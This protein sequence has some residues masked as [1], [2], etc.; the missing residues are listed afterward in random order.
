ML[1]VMNGK[2]SGGFH[3]TGPKRRHADHSYH[4]DGDDD[5]D[6]DDDDADEFDADSM[7]N[8]QRCERFNDR[9][10]SAGIHII[11]IS[12]LRVTRLE[13]FKRFK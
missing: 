13:H 6:D 2:G 3:M 8:T 1:E 12:E 10:S 11:V 5:D 4:A 7:L 9:D